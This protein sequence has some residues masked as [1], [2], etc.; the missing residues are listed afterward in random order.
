MY[1]IVIAT[2][3]R[4]E[5]L[6]KTIE[7]ICNQLLLPDKIIIIDSSDTNLPLSF[8]HKLDRNPSII[9]KRVLYKSAALQRNEGA[10]LV[11]SEFVIF[12]DDDVEFTN[13]FFSEI[14]KTISEHNLVAVGPRQINAE[15]PPPGRI[16]KLYYSLQAGYIDKS[17]GGRLFGVGI[18]C[19]P[20]FELQKEEL[21]PAEWLPSTCLII[22]T[23]VFNQ[24]KFPAFDGYSFGEDVFLTASIA[25]KYPLFWLSTI[26]YLHHSAPTTFKKNLSALRK[27]ALSNQR[28]IAEEIIGLKGWKL[29][30]KLFLHK[31][32]LNLVRIK[33][34]NIRY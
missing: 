14:F 22:N 20:C 28:L 24:F 13:S 2:L 12:L 30:Y 18:N 21:L 27:M 32:F 16:L 31:L 33:Q 4:Y 1:S 6:E 19:Y 5:Y 25:K 23:K 29:R 15:I 7:Y 10:E 3:N 8:K 11:D 9:Y 26:S 17:F 34:A